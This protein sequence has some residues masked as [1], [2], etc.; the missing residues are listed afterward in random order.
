MFYVFSIV[1]N[2][3]CYNK[4]NI[5]K[6]FNM[7]FIAEFSLFQLFAKYTWFQ[8]KILAQHRTNQ[9]QSGTTIW[10]FSK[11]RADFLHF[12]VCFSQVFPK[13]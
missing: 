10:I 6:L 3:A 12:I 1:N 5:D 11:R 13:D 8:K 4:D 2:A 7:E 9:K